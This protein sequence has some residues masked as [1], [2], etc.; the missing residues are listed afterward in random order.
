[1]FKKIGYLIDY[2]RYL[3]NPIDA[4]KFKFGV[5]DSVDLKIN[6]VTIKLNN[7]D[8]LNYT[9]I[10][11]SGVRDNMMTNCANYLKEYFNEKFIHIEGVKFINV[12]FPDFQKNSSHKYITHLGEYILDFPNYSDFIK[13]DG[14]HIVDIGAN[15]ADSTLIFAKQGAEVLAFEPVPHIYELALENIALNPM[16]VDK[17]TLINKGVGAKKGTLSLDSIMVGEYVDDS[18]LNMEIISFKD[19]LENYN[20]IPDILKMDCEGCEFEIIL[21]YDLSMFNEIIFEHHSKDINKDY[22]L[23]IDRLKEQ[24]FKIKTVEYIFHDFEDYGL[25]YAF[26]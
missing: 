4:L 8:Q 26:K 10:F 9:M 3:D 20:F 5:N 16:L 21:N 23:L 18:S 1:M 17:I 14:R 22:N 25:I 15:V 7:V 11:I 6:G 24:G 19:L 12:D 2:F 13:V